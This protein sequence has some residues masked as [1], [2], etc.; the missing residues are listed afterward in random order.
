MLELSVPA[1]A[2]DA[3]PPPVRLALD[4]SARRGGP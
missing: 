4:R 1:L 2:D 3:V